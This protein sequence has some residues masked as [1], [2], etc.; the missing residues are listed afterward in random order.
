MINNDYFILGCW[1]DLDVNVLNNY[2][3]SSG[4]P[5]KVEWAKK[6]I[7]TKLPIFAIPTGELRELAKMIARGN[8]ESYLDCKNFVSHEACMIYGILLNRLREVSLV[9]K[10]MKAYAEAVDNWALC[11]VISLKVN[12]K[13]YLEFFELAKDYIDSNKEFSKRIGIK[14]LFKLVKYKD[15]HE[16]IFKLIEKFEEEDEYYVNMVLAWL[17][18]E[19]FIK[20]RDKTLEFFENGKLN[21]FVINKAISK[22][23][24]SFRVSKE[25]KKMLLKFKR[26]ID[27]E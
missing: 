3:H 16:E 12:D 22:C 2:L 20:F 18:A 25:D 5:E 24:D 7:N 8:M 11:D 1:T 15:L 13:N 6:I 10:Y 14:M 19:M 27:N 21:D 4:K 26:T 17:L 23:R 9:K